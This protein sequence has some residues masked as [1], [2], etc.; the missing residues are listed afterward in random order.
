MRRNHNIEG[1]SSANGS[2]ASIN[3]K[4]L[5]RKFSNLAGTGHTNSAA[6]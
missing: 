2:L 6:L 3:S 5:K 4:G 1:G